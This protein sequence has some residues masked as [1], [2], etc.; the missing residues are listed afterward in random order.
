MLPMSLQSTY[1]WDPWRGKWDCIV[2]ALVPDKTLFATFLLRRSI[3]WGLQKSI[4]VV[5]T[6]NTPI[7]FN[8]PAPALSV[9]LHL[10]NQFVVSKTTNVALKLV[11]K[12]QWLGYK[13]LFLFLFS[14]RTTA[15]GQSINSYLQGK[16][17]LE[18]H[19]IH[20]LFSANRWEAV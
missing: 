12:I 7:I 8:N 6:N 9:L 15:I 10:W 14:D 18:D 19:A 11:D 13:I 4:F 5:H 20:L 16:T 1:P 17:E 2:E 3:I